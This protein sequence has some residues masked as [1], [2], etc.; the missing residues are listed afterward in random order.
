MNTQLIGREDFAT[1]VRELCPI[2]ERHLGTADDDI[3]YWAE[4]LFSHGLFH[5]FSYLVI[6][7]PTDL[8][9]LKRVANALKELKLALSESAMTPNTLGYLAEAIWFG[10]GVRNAWTDPTKCGEY[11]GSGGREDLH[12]F[13]RLTERHDEIQEAVATTIMQVKE[14]PFSRRTL[15]Q[16][17]VKAIGLADACCYVWLRCKGK[18]PPKDIKQSSPFTTFLGEPMQAFS[19][20]GDPVSTYRAWARMQDQVHRSRQSI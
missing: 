13:E 5:G 15:S 4:R 9:A 18:A 2:L 7:G 16:F 3:E 14:S 17:N 10:P 1:L 12:A 6:D 11:T 20:K 8:A 19:I